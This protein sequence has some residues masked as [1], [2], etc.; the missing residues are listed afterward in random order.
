MTIWIMPKNTSLKFVVSFEIY[1]DR[2]KYNFRAHPLRHLLE[3]RF[4]YLLHI[5]YFSNLREN[6]QVLA[7]IAAHSTTFYISIAV[8]NSL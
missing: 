5:C 6:S 1:F 2:V 3:W 8:F 7:T 4:P